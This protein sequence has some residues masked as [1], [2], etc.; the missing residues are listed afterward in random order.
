MKRIA[1]L[2]L[3]LLAC[4]PTGELQERSNPFDPGAGEYFSSRYRVAVVGDS[5]SAGVNA[6]LG[7]GAYGWAA[8]QLYGDW[9]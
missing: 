2:S 9:R 4:S 5:V 3:L 6:E 1:V 7:T 8:F